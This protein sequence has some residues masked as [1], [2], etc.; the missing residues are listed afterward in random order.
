MA[1]KPN[2]TPAQTAKQRA[3]FFIER[4]SLLCFYK[5]SFAKPLERH[6]DRRGLIL[7]RPVLRHDPV[8][9][10]EYG[11]RRRLVVHARR[12]L[13]RKPRSDRDALR[14][15]R[16]QRAKHRPPL[17]TASSA[18]II[19][20]CVSFMD[21]TSST[22]A[23]CATNSHPCAYDISTFCKRH[24]QLVVGSFRD[25]PL[26]VDI[27]ISLRRALTVPCRQ[28]PSSSGGTDRRSRGTRPCR[29]PPSR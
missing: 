12:Y 20:S 3:E 16:A 21:T 23:Y 13:P 18:A 26:L 19:L 17:F 28:H 24:W 6:L 14:T 9:R 2:A 11:F 25:D 7:V 10:G 1:V 29:P 8:L 4:S 27:V 15:R 5:L 22:G